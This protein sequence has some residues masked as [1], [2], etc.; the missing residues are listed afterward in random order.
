MTATPVEEVPAALG[1]AAVAEEVAVGAGL[2]WATVMGRRVRPGIL[3]AV[4]QEAQEAQEAQEERRE[5]TERMPSM[6]TV[7][8][9]ATAARPLS[10]WPVTKSLTM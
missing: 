5:G 9:A 7:A 1:T 6:L 10:P 2:M 8:T 4:P 3:P